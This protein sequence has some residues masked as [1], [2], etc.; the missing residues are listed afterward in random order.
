MCAD[1][2][3]ERYHESDKIRSREKDIIER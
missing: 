2:C 3:G 1:L